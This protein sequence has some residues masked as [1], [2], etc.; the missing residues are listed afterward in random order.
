VTDKELERLLE[1]AA[2]RG[3]RGWYL[4][5]ALAGLRRSELTRLTW[6]S[7]DLEAGLLTIRDGKAK[8]ED[9]VPLHP[10]LRAELKVGRPA[11]AK[12]TDRVFPTAVTNLTRKLDF[13]RAGTPE[14]DEQGRVTDLHGLRATLGTRLARAGIAPQVAQRIMRHA[15]YRTTLKHYT[16]LSLADTTAAMHLLPGGRGDSALRGHRF[17]PLRTSLRFPETEKRALSRFLSSR[18]T[19]QRVV[20]RRCAMER[21]TPTATTPAAS[22]ANNASCASRRDAVRGCA[23]FAARAESTPNPA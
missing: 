3:R 13:K 12:P 22:L 15:D 16:M 23:A 8:R 18:S 10:E 2:E 1:V 11:D 5:A 4:A 21:S 6:A 9:V 7:V 19:I 20:K 14:V 17:P